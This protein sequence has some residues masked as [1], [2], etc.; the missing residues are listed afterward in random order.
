MKDS[1]NEKIT[2]FANRLSTSVKTGFLN[3]RNIWQN[4][5]KRK[6]YLSILLLLVI[7]NLLI[8]NIL[9]TYSYYADN[10]GFPLIHA[11]V[12]NLYFE[13]YD[14]V[15]LIY[16]EN[17]NNKGEGSGEY[18]LVDDI[19]TYGYNYSGYKCNNN[20]T[21]I[22]NEDTKTTAVNLKNKDICSVYFNLAAGSDFAF[23][24]MLEDKVDSNQYVLSNN[25][26]AY[27]YEYSHYECPNGSSLLYD[28]D[29]HKVT[30][31]GDKKDYCSIYFKKKNE[32]IITNVYV[33]NNGNKTFSKVSIIPPNVRY[34]LN[35]EKSYCLNKKNERN[36]EGITY[37]NGNVT[38]TTNEV[39]ECNV[40]LD[41]N[42]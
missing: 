17:E 33:G 13:D 5:Q 35:N 24:V 28:G 12:G 34:T 26:P 14:Y 18:H 21:I 4:P 30:M 23:K 22:Y 1:L 16:L 10:I 41:K 40:Y 29:L 37:T 27:G 8:I 42:E 25:I 3:L 39:V 7:V 9:N 19:P 36:T 38:I 2:N 31:A 11:K 6:K 32:D 20:S 15:L